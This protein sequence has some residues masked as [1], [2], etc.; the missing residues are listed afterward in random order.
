MHVAQT[1]RLVL[2]I[3]APA[4]QAAGWRIGSRLTLQDRPGAATV[5]SISPMVS[6]A[7][8]T[9]ALRATLAPGSTLRPGELVTVRLPL[10]RDASGWDVP[11]AAVARD[12]QQAVVFVRNRDRFCGASREGD[13]RRGA[14]RARGRGAPGG[15]PGRRLRRGGLEGGVAGP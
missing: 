5:A 3:Q 12:G 14:A 13:G 6:G 2:D 10:A 11:L 1:D 15:G 7:S 9:V 4:A 8:Q